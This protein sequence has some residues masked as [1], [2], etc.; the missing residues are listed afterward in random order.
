[1][2]PL[3]DS[4]DNPLPP[5]FDETAHHEPFHSI[6]DDRERRGQVLRRT[7]PIL[8]IPFVVAIVIALALR[9]TLGGSMEARVPGAWS[10]L[11]PI[12]VVACFF[13]ALVMSVRLGRANLSAS[14]L[15][16]AWT[17][18]AVTLPFLWQASIISIWP[19]L[20][21]A[22]ICAAGLLIDGAAS[23]VLAALATLLVLTLGWLQMEGFIPMSAVVSPG[24]GQILAILPVSATAFW[25]AM[26]WMIA[27]LT[28]LLAG[29]LQRS[30]EYNR[31]LALGLRRFSNELEAR[32]AQQT[33]ELL[34]QSQE[35]A[36]LEERT[37]VARDIHDTLAQGLTGI[38]VQLGAAQRALEAES[39]DTAEH[40]ELA[41]SMAREALAE[42]RRSIWNLRAPALERG[43]L[44]DA[45][46]G[47]VERKSHGE[48]QIDFKSMGEVWQLASDVES[49][50]L[51][52]CQESLVNVTKHAGATEA[53]VVLEYA[54]DL[55]RFSVCDNGAGFDD[56]TLA[57]SHAAQGP[58]DGFGLLGMRERIQQFG[59]TLTLSNEGGAQVEAIVPRERASR[60]MP[61]PGTE[62]R[63]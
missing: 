30:L 61:S 11:L 39:P 54:P 59:G 22:P 18:G 50:L 41:Q 47:L 15:I 52:V 19:A 32:V 55:V 33:A 7:L 40:I 49:S 1:M 63:H 17:L 21:I 35:T 5:T 58:W 31:R 53:H 20:L 37:R 62:E 42:A 36:R 23:I 4:P 46:Q 10:R 38:V 56:Q 28:Y 8:S 9:F 26:Y 12:I 2:K 27:G 51:R 3:F 13:I 34:E 57:S 16:G 45:L 43:G 48:I 44:S 24:Q 60:A 6:L 25:I 29:G 14:L